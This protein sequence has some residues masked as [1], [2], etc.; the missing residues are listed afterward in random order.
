MSIYPAERT[1]FSHSAASYGKHHEIGMW[2][3]TRMTGKGKPLKCERPFYFLSFIIFLPFHFGLSYFLLRYQN[4]ERSI[5]H[6]PLIRDYRP[7][8]ISCSPRW[9]HLAT[10]IAVGCLGPGDCR[11]R[12]HQPYCGFRFKMRSKV[13]R[14]TR[15]E[16]GGVVKASA[17]HSGGC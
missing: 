11:R 6:F 13:R 7:A 8:A 10:V 2:R 15:G 4:Y 5:I 3:F 9:P 14:W 16:D 1:G 17:L 12:P